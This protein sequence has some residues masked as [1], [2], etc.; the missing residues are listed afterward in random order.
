MTPGLDVLVQDVIA[1]M[2]TPPCRGGPG[3]GFAS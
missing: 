2:T 3:A 1:A